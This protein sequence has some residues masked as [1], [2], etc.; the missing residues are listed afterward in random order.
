ML[1]HSLVYPGTKSSPSGEIT[2]D[3][4]ST[5]YIFVQASCLQRY[6][7]SGIPTR[8]VI[9]TFKK[10]TKMKTETTPTKKKAYHQPQLRDFGTVD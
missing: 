4:N 7:I 8:H 3:S 1:L 10:R 2:Q 9:H 6:E 5:N